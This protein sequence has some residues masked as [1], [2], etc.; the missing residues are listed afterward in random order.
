MLTK[1]DTIHVCCS[2]L[3]QLCPAVI[4]CLHWGKL[5][6]S[7]IVKI[8][9]AVGCVD[10]LRTLHIACHGHRAR[11][12]FLPRSRRDLESKKHHG[13]I[14]SRSRQPPRDLAM[15]FFRFL[16]SARSRRDIF[17]LAEIAEISPRFPRSPRSR[18]D[19]CEILNLGEI[20]ARSPPSRRDYRDLLAMMFATF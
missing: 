4:F 7:L 15:M 20:A 10:H 19:L 2:A 8:Q 11:A 16:I 17:H 9:V 12:K 13:E 1:N 14:S 3:L 6:H 5:I 18:H